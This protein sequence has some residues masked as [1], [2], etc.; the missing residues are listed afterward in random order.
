[1]GSRP[2][3]TRNQPFKSGF[4]IFQIERLLLRQEQTLDCFEDGAGEGR[5]TANSDPSLTV[6]STLLS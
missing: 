1:M 2:L 6:V 3:F 4:L 5:K